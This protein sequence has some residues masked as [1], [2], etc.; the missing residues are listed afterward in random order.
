MLSDLTSQGWDAHKQ[1]LDK[2]FSEES[3]SSATQYVGLKTKLRSVDE[4][5]LDEFSRYLEDNDIAVIRLHRQSL[6]KQT[7]SSLRADELV[8]QKGLYNIEQ[9][10]EIELGKVHIG[11]SVFTER[12]H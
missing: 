6:F 8:R 10:S 5:Y 2:F 11:S 7:I 9:N 12:M 4:S 3:H 1:F